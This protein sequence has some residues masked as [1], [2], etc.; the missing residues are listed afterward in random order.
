MKQNLTSKEDATSSSNRDKWAEW[1]LNKRQG[2]ADKYKDSLPGYYP[3][4]DRVLSNARVVDGD[5]VLDVGCGDGL[6]AFGALDLVGENG[7][8]IFLDI[9]QDCLDYCIQGAESIGVSS[10]CEF[11]CCS[12]DNLIDI[13]DA[14]V[15]VVCTRSVLIYLQDKRKCFEEFYRVLKPGGRVSLFEPINRFSYTRSEK[16]GYFGISFAP[17][18]HI[19]AKYKRPESTQ[20]EPPLDDSLNRDPMLNFDQHDLIDQAFESGFTSVNIECELSSNRKSKAYPWEI[21]YL[22]AP[23]PLVPSL[24]ERLQER[25]SEEDLLEFERIMKPVVDS[26]Y[27]THHSSLVYLFAEK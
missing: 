20:T 3:I 5:V 23:N 1:L 18:D 25:F 7:K 15:D 8:V 22:G 10:H 2:G 21:F 6:I 26:A 11:K 24:K 14:S 16:N 9:S 4:R 13:P 19:F 27:I 17:V 12:A